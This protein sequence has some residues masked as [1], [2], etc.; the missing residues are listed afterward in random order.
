MARILLPVPADPS[1]IHRVIVEQGDPLV[2]VFDGLYSALVVD[3]VSGWLVIDDAAI[4]NSQVRYLSFETAIEDRSRFPLRL[5]PDPGASVMIEVYAI[6]AGEAV[7]AGIEFSALAEKEFAGA[8]VK[9]VVTVGTVE[10][11]DAG[12]AR[13]SLPADS[14][15]Y[16]LSIGKARVAFDTAGRSGE[17]INFAT[18]LVAAP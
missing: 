10:T 18:L 14:G 3:P 7:E 4:D 9:T 12:Y 2:K 8:G 5:D 11:D 1:L 15:T 17:T 13:L 6:D 16:T